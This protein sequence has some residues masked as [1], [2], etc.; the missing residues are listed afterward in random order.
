VESFQIRMPHAKMK[1]SVRAHYPV[2]SFLHTC[3]KILM[4]EKGC[5][6]GQ[7]WSLHVKGCNDCS[8]AVWFERGARFEFRLGHRLLLPNVF[9][10][11]FSCY[12]IIDS[13]FSH[14]RFLR[15]PF[16]SRQYF[17]SFLYGLH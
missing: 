1:F 8:L 11:F 4:G 3:W 10:V 12:S 14:N 13:T 5:L 6:K 17:Y 7:T 15:S 2:A 16:P 9:T